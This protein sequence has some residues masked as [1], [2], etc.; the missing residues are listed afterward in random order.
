MNATNTTPAVAYIRMSS[1]KQEASPEQQKVE[2][3]KLAE[4]GGFQIV[5]WYDD[6]GISGDSTEK[7][8]G[9]QRMIAVKCCS[10]A[11]KPNILIIDIIVLLLA[12]YQCQQTSKPSRSGK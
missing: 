7:R 11:S 3:V 6:H 8:K 2:I 5:R 9:F 1:S 10:R 12:L 4:A